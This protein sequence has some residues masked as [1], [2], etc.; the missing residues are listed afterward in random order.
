MEDGTMKLDFKCLSVL[1]RCMPSD[2]HSVVL[3][4]ATSWTA[5]CQ[6]S[7]SVE[8]CRQEYCSGLPFPSPGMYARTL[9]KKL[10]L[11]TVSD[12]S[13]HCFPIVEVI[14]TQKITFKQFTNN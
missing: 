5:A 11:A 9:L 3:D 2:S 6:A 10:G 13:Y 7:L 8:F 14:P 4:S 12:Y 1:D